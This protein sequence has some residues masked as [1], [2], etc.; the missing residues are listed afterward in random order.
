ML[1]LKIFI[2]ADIYWE[3]DAISKITAEGLEGYF[4]LQ[5][6]HIDYVAILVP[7]ILAVT[8]DNG[9]EFFF[10]VDHG[11]LVKRDSNVSISTRNAIEG[12]NIATLAQ[13][14]EEQFKQ[15]DD[16]EKKARTALT[17]LEYGMLRRFTELRKP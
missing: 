5:P 8:T 12:D 15:I 3:S 10:A 1:T 6:R 16:L 13:I 2:P 14:V 9:Q 11:T 7:G 17:G 4:T